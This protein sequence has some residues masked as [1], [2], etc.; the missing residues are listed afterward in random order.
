MD[1]KP[2]DFVK[3]L[4]AVQEEISTETCRIKDSIAKTVVSEIS[5][6]F[7]GF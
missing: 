5:E 7:E 6:K 3:G 4:N 2:L 1:N